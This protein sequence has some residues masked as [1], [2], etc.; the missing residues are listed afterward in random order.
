MSSRFVSSSRLFIRVHILYTKYYDYEADSFIE[1]QMGYRNVI[2]LIVISF[3]TN[4]TRR[5]RFLFGTEF[6]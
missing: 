2:R 1:V 3:L 5:H 4:E 6:S